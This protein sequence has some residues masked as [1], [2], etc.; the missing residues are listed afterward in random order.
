[1]SIDLPARAELHELFVYGSLVDPGC[2]DD[3]LGHAHQG[4]RLAARLVGY[5]RRKTDAFAYSFIVSAAGRSVEGVL[6]MDL[7]PCDLRALDRYEDVDA[8][9]YQRRLV[10]VEAW[11]CG[12]QPLRRCAFVYAAGPGLCSSTYTPHGP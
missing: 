8:G 6:I 4:E 7:S 2:L 12:Q 1:M 9:L 3:V 5:E 10:E 11:G